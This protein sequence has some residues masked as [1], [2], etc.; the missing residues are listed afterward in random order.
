MKASSHLCCT[1]TKFSGAELSKC[2]SEWTAEWSGY[3]ALAVCCFV[4]HHYHLKPSHSL[5][6]S[7][8]LCVGHPVSVQQDARI[9]FVVVVVIV[10]VDRY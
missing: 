5:S 2:D 9:P 10:V 4:F 8:V 7:L 1:R 3:I 6:L